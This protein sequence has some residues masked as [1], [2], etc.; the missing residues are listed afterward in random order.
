[1]KLQKRTFSMTMVA[2]MAAL[3]TIIYT[4]FPEVSLVPGIEYLKIDFSDIPALLL[5][6]T[7]GP[8]QGIMVELI[9]NL[10]HLL[11]TTTFGIG[12][13]INLGIGSALIVSMW[14]F[15]RLFS[16]ILKKKTMH[17]LT[18][19]IACALTICVAILT[20]WLL[21]TA[22]TPIFYMVM[23]WPLTTELLLAGVWGSTALNAVKAAL[24]LIPFYPA[25]YAV[26]RVLKKLK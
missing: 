12:E 8:I 18:Y 26:D 16:R 5:G 25:F 13:L 14:G 9:K 23:G 21:N 15:S 7:L 24:N 2:V 20:G 1:M 11:R 3:S 4:I 19:F 17:P 22:L 10:I 6:I